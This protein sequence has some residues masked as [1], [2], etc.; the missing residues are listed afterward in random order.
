MMTQRIILA[1][2]KTDLVNM[3]TFL[4]I[5]VIVMGFIVCGIKLQLLR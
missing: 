4:K 2:V 3:R 1:P 5:F